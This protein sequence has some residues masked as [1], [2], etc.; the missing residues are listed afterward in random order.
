MS[1]LTRFQNYFLYTKS[2]WW[3]WLFSIFCR[4]S[5]AYAFLVAGGVKI[6]G[7]RFASGLSEIH[8]MGAYLEALHHENSVFIQ[9]VKTVFEG[10]YSA[11]CPGYHFASASS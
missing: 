7:E 11:S 10:F 9:V 3:Y 2:N 4:L 5:L 1:T 6:F 8:P